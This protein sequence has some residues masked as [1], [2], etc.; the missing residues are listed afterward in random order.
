MKANWTKNN[1]QMT[2]N[3]FSSHYDSL[4][5]FFALFIASLFF[6][7]FPEPISASEDPRLIEREYE[8]TAV[9]WQLARWSNGESVCSVFMRNNKQPSADD[10]LDNCGY[11]TFI[12]W[13]TTPACNDVLPGTGGTSCQ[14]LLIRSIGEEKHVFS[15]LLQLPKIHLQAQSVNCVPGDWCAENPE[16]NLMGIEPVDGYNIER[17]YVRIGGVLHVCEGQICTVNLPQTGNDGGW[18]EYWAQSDFGDESDVVQIKF[19]NVKINSDSDTYRVDILGDDFIEYAPSGSII[20]EIFPPIDGNLPTILEQPF[21]AGYLM[22]TNR[23]V[24]LAG[25]LIKHRYVNADTCPGGGLSENMIATPCGEKAAADQVLE[26]Q[27]KY[28]DQIFNASIKYNVPARV[29]KGI[30]AQESQFWP[31]SDSPYELGLGMVTENGVD[32]LLLW[33]PS[34]YLS[35]C[36]PLFQETRCSSGYD[37]LSEI[38]KTYLKRKALDK[39]GTDEEIDLLAATLLASAVQSNQLVKNSAGKSVSW[40]ST[41]EDMW[42]F[43]IGNYNAGSGCLGTAMN[44]V[45]EEQSS[46]LWEDV[47]NILVGDCGE[48]GEYVEKVFSITQ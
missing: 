35:V 22:T 23:Y 15:E 3:L 32:L 11:Q 9:H 27:N 33:N 42:K 36:I 4:K 20:W 7:C 41:Y 14:G 5:V 39:I 47:E 43:T 29:L 37:N 48:A 24:Y 45:Y 26:W 46:I 1:D 21:S 40:V 19:R 8:T 44:S 6:F 28:N 13:M 34:Y 18:L 16:L 10:I 30:I 38:E 2:G 25:Y 17:L 12:E 31:Q